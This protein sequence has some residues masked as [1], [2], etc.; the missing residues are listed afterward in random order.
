V[1][2]H[3]RKSFLIKHKVIRVHYGKYITRWKS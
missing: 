2:N 3:N 1:Q